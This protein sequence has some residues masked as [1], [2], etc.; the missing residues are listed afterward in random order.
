MDPGALRHRFDS[1]LEFLYLFTQGLFS[2]L[3]AVSLDLESCDLKK[4]WVGISARLA[5]GG[6]WSLNP[7]DFAVWRIGE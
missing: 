2:F 3:V 6:R 7:F 1:A 5:G 4:V